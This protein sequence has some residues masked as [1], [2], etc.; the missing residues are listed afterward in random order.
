[1]L[2]LDEAV[3][4]Q[5][6]IRQWEY[7]D[8]DKAEL[9]FTNTFEIRHP[10]TPRPAGVVPDYL[11]VPPKEFGHVAKILSRYLPRCVAHVFAAKAAGKLLRRFGPGSCP[12]YCC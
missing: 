10:N 2:V 5:K 11:N 8:Y 1:V 4:L 3:A 12:D 7:A 9:E 6:D